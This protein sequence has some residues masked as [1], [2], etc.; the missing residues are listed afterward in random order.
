[1]PTSFS[2]KSSANYASKH[3]RA[4]SALNYEYS[5][6]NSIEVTFVVFFTNDKSG[7]QVT[8]IDNSEKNFDYVIG[9]K[10]IQDKKTKQ[11]IRTDI[12]NRVYFKLAEQNFQ[13][14]TVAENLRILRQWTNPAFYDLQ[15]VR[16]PPYVELC[17][18]GINIR[19]RILSLKNDVVLYKK[20]VPV[21]CYTTITLRGEPTSIVSSSS[22]KDLEYFFVEVDKATVAKYSDVY[23]KQNKL[24]WQGTQTRITTGE[25]KQGFVQRTVNKVKDIIKK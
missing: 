5:Y 7:T 11:K 4:L 22:G 16:E 20:G 15:Y 24:L 14:N 9:T 3:K 10:E 6:S 12:K 21:R 25:G 13:V 19:G 2:I 18:A 23:N 17:N 8:G 1:F